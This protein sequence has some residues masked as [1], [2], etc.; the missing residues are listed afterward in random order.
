MSQE[1]SIHGIK[2]VMHVHVHVNVEE[3]LQVHLQVHVQVHMQ[4]HVPAH[5]LERRWL[6]SGLMASPVIRS[7]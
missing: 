3:H 4:V 6:P 7:V 5:P 2:W 1:H